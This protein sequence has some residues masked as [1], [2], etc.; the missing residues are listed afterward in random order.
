MLVAGADTLHVDVMDGNFVPNISFGTPAI[1]G[2]KKHTKDF[3]YV[4]STDATKTEHKGAFLDCHLMVVDPAFWLPVFEQIGVHGFTFHYEATKTEEAAIELLTNIKKAGMRSGIALKPGTPVDVL[5]PAII[6]VADMVLIMTVEP[7]FGGQKF[8]A[9]MMPK[10]TTLR[11]KYP[12]LLIQ[13]D[14][15]I[16]VNTIST[17]A[18]AGANVIV[19][20]SGVFGAPSP[21]E[22]IQIMKDVVNAAAENW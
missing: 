14:G 4:I 2:L 12:E 10:V 22:A 17:V 7:G 6:A 20:G 3:T 1:R 21:A 19:S 9:D 15:G 11:Q 18:D 13:V 16:D 5:T 8:M